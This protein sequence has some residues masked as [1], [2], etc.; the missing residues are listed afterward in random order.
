MPWPK[1]VRFLL[2]I[3]DGMGRGGGGEVWQQLCIL[4]GFYFYYLHFFLLA[5]IDLF[6]PESLVL[7]EKYNLSLN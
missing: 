4:R 5:L 2:Q 7:K 6:T 1:Y 3:F